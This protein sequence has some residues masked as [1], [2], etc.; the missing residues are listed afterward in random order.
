MGAIRVQISVLQGDNRVL[1]AELDLVDDALDSDA[2][3]LSREGFPV[4]TGL[5]QIN[6]VMDS[7]GARAHAVLEEHDEG[8]PALSTA[9]GRFCRKTCIRLG[10]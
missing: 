3:W 7:L 1:Q 6:Q 5:H 8:D 10:H 2:S 9:L 4:V